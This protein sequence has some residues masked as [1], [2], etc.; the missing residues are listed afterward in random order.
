MLTQ[1][2]DNEG[3]CT[4]WRSCTPH[5]KELARSW[6]RLTICS[7]RTLRRMQEAVL[8]V[9]VA[10]RFAEIAQ[11]QVDDR[12]EEYNRLAEE[13]VAAE[14]Y[15]N[16][17]LGCIRDLER[18]AAAATYSL[19][20]GTNDTDSNEVGTCTWPWTCWKAF[21]ARTPTPRRLRAGIGS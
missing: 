19:S 2:E 13:Y 12:R 7:T 9:K 3:F 5:L 8:K 10:Q 6:V 15:L 18:G 16:E 17:G 1:P 14:G 21:C 20:C 11:E 4:L